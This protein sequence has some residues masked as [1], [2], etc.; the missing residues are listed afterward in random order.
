VT[1]PNAASR[2]TPP[3]GLARHATPA[4]GQSALAP[5][6]EPYEPGEGF[7]DGYAPRDPYEQQPTSRRRARQAE[8]PEPPKPEEPAAPQQ[9]RT[10]RE[11][12][13][14]GRRRR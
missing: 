10:R 3:T 14:Q 4:Y 12:K 6:A 8:P 2:R 7:F 13:A 5:D 11:A 9:P 1:G